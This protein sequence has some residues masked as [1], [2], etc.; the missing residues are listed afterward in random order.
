M[1]LFKVQSHA[2][3][4][5]FVFT[6]F[7]SLCFKNNIGKKRLKYKNFFGTHNCVAPELCHL[8]DPHGGQQ[9]LPD[10]QLKHVA[11]HNFH[12]CPHHFAVIYH[13]AVII[14]QLGAEVERHLEAKGRDY[15]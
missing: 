8:S 9:S 4:R 2:S 6:Y 1:S 15:Q 5:R 7:N 13:C 3:Q 14:T 10:V 12:G 11:N